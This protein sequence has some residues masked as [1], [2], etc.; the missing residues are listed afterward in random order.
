VQKILD[1]D[2]NP[3]QY[4]WN[5]R[6]LL[7]AGNEDEGAGGDFHTHSDQIH[8]T[9]PVTFTGLR[10]YFCTD[11]CSEYYKYDDITLANDMVVDYLNGGGLLAS[12]VGHS[13]WDQWAVDP[14]TFAPLF[15]VD[16]DVPGLRNGGTLPVFLGMTCYTGRF[17]YSGNDTLDESLLR[18]AG[19]GAV[20]TWGSTTLGRTSGHNILH[21]RFFHAVFEDG[22]TELGTV[23]EFA[24]L[25]LIGYDDSDL[26]DTFVLLG[27]PAMDLNMTIV[28][29]TDQ[30]FLPLVLR[31]G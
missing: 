7:F 1:Y 25:G 11:G 5:E 27:D 13:S 12:Y 31:G 14:A 8:A 28:P 17:S 20:A 3:P 9:L 18:R 24:K 26:I 4:P 23:T 29:W 16:N 2:L 30:V 19:G 15:H 6:V 10:A 22:A 21:Q